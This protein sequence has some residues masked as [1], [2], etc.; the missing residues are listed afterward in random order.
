MPFTP[1][2]FGPALLAKSCARKFSFTIFVFSQVVM[3]SEPLYFMLRQDWP[4]HRLFHTFLGCNIP[5]LITLFF[6]KFICEI[7]L[8]AWNALGF[9]GESRIS[10]KITFLSA[11]AGTYSH[12][13]FDGLMH[14]DMQPFWP[15]VSG[16]PLLQFGVGGNIAPFC[17]LCA[18]AGVL[19][20]FFRKIKRES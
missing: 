12:V 16:N 19:I 9:K 6:G 1:L 2:H 7:W 3:D 14:R 17:V 5:L 13:L 20:Y 11:A 4:A 15:V 8:K 18:A 10:W